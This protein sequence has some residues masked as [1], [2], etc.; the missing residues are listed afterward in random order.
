LISLASHA[1][2]ALQSRA[3][4]A[5]DTLSNSAVSDTSNPPKNRQTTISA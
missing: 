5:S 1:L 4:V 2:A 3:T